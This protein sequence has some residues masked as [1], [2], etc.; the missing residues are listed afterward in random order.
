MLE[1]IADAHLLVSEVPPGGHPTRVGFLAR[2]RLIAA[3]TQGTVLVEAAVRSGARNTASWATR[4]GRVLMAVPGS[5]LSAASVTPNRLIRD[6]EAVL[7]TSASDVLAELGPLAAAES[8]PPLDTLRE[9]D[10]LDPDERAVIDAF[11]ARAARTAAEITVAS[12]VTYGAC[13][14]LLGSLAERGLVER[15]ASG[16]WRLTAARSVTDVRAGP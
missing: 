10:D 15:T 7:V 1:R 5:V 14:G 9:W 13:L 8:Q 12:G 16:E 2:N 6:G 3:L 4:L 11:P